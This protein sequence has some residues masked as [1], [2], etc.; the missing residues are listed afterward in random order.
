MARL[1]N[2]IL[3]ADFWSDG[4]LLRW[5]R[6]K[7]MTYAGLYALA[8]D[9]GCMQDDCFNW[10]ILLW[11]SPLDADITVEKLEQWRDEL[12]EAGKLIPY[13]SDHEECLYIKS[14]HEHEHPRN[15]QAPST[16]LPAWITWVPLKPK[17]GSKWSESRRGH[18]EVAEVSTNGNGKAKRQIAAPK[19]T[20]LAKRE[21]DDES[22]DM[23][24][25][26]YP[27]TEDKLRARRA[28]GRLTNGE[29]E[30]AIG[31]A[32]VMGAMC[33][34]KQQDPKYVPYASKFIN[35][36]EWENWRH[37]IPVGWVDGD[38]ALA[39]QN[40]ASIDEAIAAAYGEDES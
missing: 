28:W 23:F 11:G 9:S 21:K 40:Q 31:V 8:D 35:G 33:A 39:A 26:F 6:E 34:S 15:P 12:I 3:K 38:A 14:F 10:K 7:R 37:G 30:L 24:W 4:E 5:P 13:V 19:K 36:K 17:P 29:R 20:G 25:A 32:Q 18:Y 16:P 1:R 2:R 22:F 27:R